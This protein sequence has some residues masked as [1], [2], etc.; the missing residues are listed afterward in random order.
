[1]DLL[2]Q[3]GVVSPLDKKNSRKILLT[4]EQYRRYKQSLFTLSNVR[5]STVEDELACVDAMEGHD[6]EHWGAVCSGILA[7]QKSEVIRGKRQSKE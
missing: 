4:R 5:A 6:F 3:V 7:L 2:E 1:M